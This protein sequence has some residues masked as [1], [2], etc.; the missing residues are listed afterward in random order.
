MAPLYQM[1]GELIHY[2]TKCQ[3]D[4]NHRITLM[5]GALPARILCLTCKTE[6]AYRSIPSKAPTGKRVTAAVRAATA[7]AKTSEDLDWRRK[8]NDP[9]KT[10]KPYAPLGAYR[11]E[12]HIYHPT[13]GKGVVA[14]FVHP[15]KIQIYFEDGLKLLKGA[16]A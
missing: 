5:K 16:R 7:K 9:D 15:D 14:G 4:L 3:L 13:F 2:C 10:P 11:A 12:D 8:L 1:L 6:R